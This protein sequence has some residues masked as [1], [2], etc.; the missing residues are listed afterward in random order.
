MLEP[1]FGRV[2]IIPKGVISHGDMHP[3]SINPEP[4]EFARL[5]F[6][7]PRGWRGMIVDLPFRGQ[8]EDHGIEMLIK[9]QS[10]CIYV[11]LILATCLFFSFFFFH[12]SKRDPVLTW[13]PITAYTKWRNCTPAPTARDDSGVRMRPIDTSIRYT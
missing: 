7:A 1:D 4:Y 8:I 6:N 10:L 11:Y 13:L 9:P 3:V 5:D 2:L 12:R